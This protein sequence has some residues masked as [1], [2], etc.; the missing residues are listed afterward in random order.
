MT[1]GK[2]EKRR[3]LGAFIVEQL[4]AQG[5][6][7][8]ELGCCDGE[9]SP[10]RVA[11]VAANVGQLLDELGRSKRD[12]VVM[13]R[14]DQETARQLDAWVE[15]GAVRSR[16]EAAALF[17]REGL[18]VRAPELD[19]L[20]DAISEVGRAR[21]RLRERVQEVLGTDVSQLGT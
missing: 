18:E 5:V 20:K 8:T 4:E 21:E 9:G 12:Q 15:T 19:Q 14:V 2:G 16:S 10:I 7:L 13:V 3:D 17:M 11:C 1:D 6:D